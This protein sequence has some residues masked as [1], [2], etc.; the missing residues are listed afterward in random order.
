MWRQY[1]ARH[2]RENKAASIFL[3]GMSFIASLLLSLLS[4]IAYNLWVDYVNRQTVL[5][6]T[7]TPQMEPVLAAYGSVLLIACAALISMLHHAFAVSMNSRVHQLGILASVGATPK[8]VRG[9]LT[10]EALSLCSIPVLAGII[11]GIGLCYGFMEIIIHVSRDAVGNTVGYEVAFTYHVLVAFAA[12][13]CSFFTIFLSAWIPARKLSRIS[14]LAAIHYGE[15]AAVSKMRRF[16]IVSKLSGIYGELARKSLYAR[17]KMM[18]TSALSLT[19]SCLALFAFLSFETISG[20]FTQMTYFERFRDS[21]DF[22]LTVSGREDAEPLLGAIREMRGVR[23]CIAYRRTEG[24]AV[25]FVLDEESFQTYCDS[26]GVMPDTAGAVALNNDA[27]QGRPEELTVEIQGKMEVFSLT[28]AQALPLFREEV[29]RLV[30]SIV[31]SETT[32]RNTQ[33]WDSDNRTNYNIRLLPDADQESLEEELE[34]LMA[35]YLSD[36]VSYSLEGRLE[37]EASDASIRAALRFFIGVLAGLLAAIGI[38]NVFSAT[39]GQLYQRRREFARYLS[40]GMSPRGMWR[41]LCREALMVVMSPIL[42]AVLADVPLIWWAL[43][44]SGTTPERFFEE[45]PMGM[46]L[47]FLLFLAAGIGLA[48]VLGG[49]RIICADLIETLRDETIV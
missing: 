39:L 42:L 18:R 36:G 45:L 44:Q 46:I 34:A 14:P 28:Y 23:D 22:M 19:L 6:G 27:L 35:E 7:Y 8:Q 15:E 38:M 16:S 24:T 9:F 1:L 26:A 20:N 48:Y 11:A 21:W 3:S 47:P 10:V 13:I 32:C 29:S 2:I 41:M 43:G 49:R 33:L 40:V 12:L 5:Y 31:I 25:V 17:R 37:E 4:G 30:P